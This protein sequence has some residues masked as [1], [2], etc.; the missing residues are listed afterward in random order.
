MM[1]GPM[2]ILMAIS[3]LSLAP[4]GEQPAGF[5]AGQLDDTNWLPWVGC[6]EGAPDDGGPGD[7][8]FLVCFRPTA[9]GLG[10]DIETWSEGTLGSVETL[11]AD[12]SAMA[13]SE[14]GCDGEQVARWSDD[15]RRV[16]LSSTLNCG[17]GLERT[18]RGTLS[19]LP[20]PLGWAEIHGVRSGDDAAVVGM[21]TFLPARPDDLVAFGISDPASGREL[22]VA[23][24]RT[25][26][27][28]PLSAESVAELVHEAGASVT[29]ALVAERG[30]AFS[31]D[32]ST[33]RTL[34]DLGVPG[35]V[36]DVM[37]AVT[38][39]ERF[40]VTGGARDL[41]AEV[42]EQPTAAQATAQRATAPWPATRSSRI[43]GYSPFGFRFHDPYWY[44]FGYRGGFYGDPFYFDPYFGG[45][46]IIVIEAPTV[47]DQPRSVLSR[48]R[49]VVT[50]GGAAGA[51][52]ATPSTGGTTR[53]ATPQPAPA[54]NAPSTRST[55]TSSSG[56]PAA[57]RT[58]QSG[59][60]GSTT[61]TGSTSYGGGEPVRRAVP[62]TPD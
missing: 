19:F 46:R 26:A 5:E 36:I 31:L 15:G 20:E 11:R 33:L 17:A 61:N 2:T 12:G 53:N 47:V 59:G 14:G 41:R 3:A 60:S 51:P 7:N 56:T 37:V 24:A 52:P 29:S 44:G 43:R 54:A 45:P 57:P 58:P 42:V 22:A 49:G 8:P 55:P 48:T 23:T 18:T 32:S 1:S 10:V 62:R 28:R 16:F 35:D 27:A 25:R 6:W 4:V 21:R 30:E 13:V 9:D 38:Y 40:T 34:A 50:E 39:P